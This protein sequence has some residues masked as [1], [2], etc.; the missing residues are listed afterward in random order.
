MKLFLVAIYVSV[1]IAGCSTTKY[2]WGNYETNLY[3]HYKNPAEQEE[4][5]INLQEIIADA[6]SSNGLVPPGLY[7][8]CGYALYESGKISDAIIFYKKEHD[9]WPESRFL[10]AKMITNAETKGKNTDKPASKSETT[11]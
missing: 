7:A 2:Q 6:E 11:K 4:Y 8:E 10:M 5:L 9:L 3:S 1:F